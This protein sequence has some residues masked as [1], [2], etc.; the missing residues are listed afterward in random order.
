MLCIGWAS[1][2]VVLAVFMAVILF[3]VVLA[4]GSGVQVVVELPVVAEGI[5]GISRARCRGHDGLCL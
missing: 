3:G 2:A 4:S 1:F 5:L